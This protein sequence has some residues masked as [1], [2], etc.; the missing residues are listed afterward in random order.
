MTDR[1]DRTIFDTWKLT[2]EL[3]KFILGQEG[4]TSLDDWGGKEVVREILPEDYQTNFD[5][6]QTDLVNTILKDKNRGS[7]FAFVDNIMKYVDWANARLDEGKPACYHYFP[8]SVEIMLA[9]DVVPIC[10]E[11]V[12]GLTSALYTDGAEEGVD[13]IEAE[14]YPD[15]LCSTQKGT[16]GF[17]L[18]GVVPH[19][20]LL[21]K[22]A[23]PC[24]AS[25]RLY[26]WTSHKFDTPLVVVET[27]YYRNERGQKYMLGEIKRMIE[28]LE[29]LTGNTLD[30]DKLREYIGYGNQ[31][32][33][34]ILKTQELKKR[35][36][37]PD[38]GW[39]RPAD[40]IFMTQIGTPMGAAYFKALYEDVKARADRGEG[41]IPEGK[42]ERR[43]TYGYTWECY[44]LP[45]FD[46]L[47]EEHGVSYITDTLTYFPPDVGLVDTTSMDTILEGLA[48]R[49]M[50]M[51]MGRQTMGFSDIWINDFVHVVKN[52]KADAL[53]LG[54]HMAC[55]HFWA[56]NKLLS[57][58]VKEE[59][60]VPT[61]RFEMDMFDKRFTPPA[62]LRRIMNEFFTTL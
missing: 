19:P 37:C 50:Q 41:V 1:K 60:G 42:K 9:L 7:A 57:D 3:A 29:K 31:A 13:R 35:R 30:E 14:G 17:L 39:H 8:I 47:E 51:P 52:F 2:G 38:T 16:A 24:D 12:C 27:P 40:T 33:E 43:V 54:G 10:Y 48:W 36:P 11:V 56:L 28:Q 26:E 20:D 34:Y 55:K 21:I 45:F 44:D 53:I 4:L 22:T 59:T 15:H 32:M 5:K 6:V 46:W 25:N 18:M 62:E 49:T 58:K 23:T 61:L